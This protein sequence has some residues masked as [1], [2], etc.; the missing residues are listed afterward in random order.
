MDGDASG[1]SPGFILDPPKTRENMEISPIPNI[2]SPSDVQISL[3]VF[4]RSPTLPNKWCKNT[5]LGVFWVFFSPSSSSLRRAEALTSR[6]TRRSAFPGGEFSSGPD[7]KRSILF[8]QDELSATINAHSVLK[9][10][11]SSR[12]ARAH[13]R[14][15]LTHLH[16][17]I[18]GPT[19]R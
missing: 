13:G 16:L 6:V 5:A 4:R 18:D 15:R 9:D 2:T 11:P 1:R 10:I 17:E 7:K 8:L 19:S 12:N 14:V 3:H